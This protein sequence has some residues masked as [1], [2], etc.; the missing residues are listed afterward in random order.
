M[1][2][3]E[4]INILLK[5]AKKAS[6]KREIPVAA[7]I[8]YKNKIIAKSYN[9]KESKK[10][11]MAHAE[12]LAI[13]KASKK[14]KTWNLNDCSL[15]VTLKPCKMCEEIIKQSRIEKVYYLLDKLDYKHE[16][17]K[18][19]FIKISDKNNINSYQQLLSK[20]FKNMR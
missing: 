19:K 7:I 20:F 13:K 6:K 1:E 12:I 5:L 14:L 11:I 3:K 15:Y 2:E 17:N 16:F 8:V 9:L 4:L 10:D 18:T